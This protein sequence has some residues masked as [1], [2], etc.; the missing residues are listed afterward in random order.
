MDRYLLR[1]AER[2]GKT[3]HELLTGQPGR[4]SMREL[5][6]W[7]GHDKLTAREMEKRS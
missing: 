2:L 5:I 1:L 6:M 3:R 7:M 4:L